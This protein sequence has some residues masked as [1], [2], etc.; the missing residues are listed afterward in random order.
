MVIL[1]SIGVFYVFFYSLRGTAYCWGSRFLFSSVISSVSFSRHFKPRLSLCSLLHT[2]FFFRFVT[3]LNLQTPKKMLWVDKYRPITLDQITVH[4]DV[5]Q[6]LKKLVTKFC[7]YF[8]LPFLI[9]DFNLAFLI[10]V[11]RKSSS[12][13]QNRT[14]LICSSMAPPVPERKP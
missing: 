7:C 6:N 3:I 8:F 10:W 9:S 1:K 11:F 4:Q 5:A 2:H 13:L 12:R 14:A